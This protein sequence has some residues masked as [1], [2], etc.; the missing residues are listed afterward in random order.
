MRRIVAL[1][2]VGLIGFGWGVVPV[3]AAGKP[4]QPGS[5]QQ[6]VPHRATGT[7]WEQRDTAIYVVSTLNLVRCNH[8]QP[9]SSALTAL[10]VTRYDVLADTNVQNL[11]FVEARRDNGSL[12]GA[13]AYEMG[14]ARP[15]AVTSFPVK[16]GVRPASRDI[17]QSY[18]VDSKQLM[19]TFTSTMPT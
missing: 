12:V 15:R 4:Q 11:Y 10:G 16:I 8:R 6:R 13:L 9:L 7:N 19:A 18:K 1:L 17:V 3:G 14:W 2:L 5:P